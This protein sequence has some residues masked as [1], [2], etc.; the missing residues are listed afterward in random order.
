MRKRRTS[1]AR[2]HFSG[3][4]EICV[5][6]FIQLPIAPLAS[7][8]DTSYRRGF[9]AWAQ[10][11]GD[12]ATDKAAIFT[13]DSQEEESLSTL[14]TGW[15]KAQVVVASPYVEAETR[16]EEDCFETQT[17]QGPLI[18]RT[19][20]E[21]MRC[22]P[23]SPIK[24][25]QMSARGLLQLCQE[26][27]GMS[28]SVLVCSDLREVRQRRDLPAIVSFADE[29]LVVT[30]DVSTQT[31]ANVRRSMNVSGLRSAG[32]PFGEAGYSA[33]F[34]RS[35]SMKQLVTGLYAQSRVEVGQKCS[36]VFAAQK[37]RSRN[38]DLMRFPGN[39]DSILNADPVRGVTQ[40]RGSEIEIYERDW[41]CTY[42]YC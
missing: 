24:E 25:T 6:L 29:V 37:N 33:A 32:R 7:H 21:A 35:S 40:I 19:R 18:A 26:H 20:F 34:R 16:Y 38:R 30:R 10:T 41:N 23:S 4:R 1:I 36:Q 9:R 8:S 3:F 39:S 17:P 42:A 27:Q 22:S 5:R 31:L 15:A 13:L 11:H 14:W 12:P 2:P 28:A